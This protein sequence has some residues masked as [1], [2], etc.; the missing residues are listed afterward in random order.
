MTSVSMESGSVI[1]QSLK[2]N[3]FFRDHKKKNSIQWRINKI[4]KKQVF[5]LCVVSWD[6]K[7]L[8]LKLIHVDTGMKSPWCSIKGPP[9]PP[10][11]GSFPY[12][13]NVTSCLIY[14]TGNCYFWVL[15]REGVC[16]I[17]WHPV[18][19]GLAAHAMWLREDPG[20]RQLGLGAV[21]SLQP[22]R[23]MAAEE[24]SRQAKGK[25]VMSCV[26]K[27]Q[28]LGQRVAQMANTSVTLRRIN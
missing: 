7:G 24:D 4:E 25:E 13:L 1:F 21:L 5:F 2:E 27:L 17:F 10:R 15:F 9:K 22:A 3:L 28:P 20:S 6:P 11:L 8:S 14:A 12:K 23:E 18:C 19:V 16:L 26:C